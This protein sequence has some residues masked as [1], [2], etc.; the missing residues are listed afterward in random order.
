MEAFIAH[1]RIPKDAEP[2]L[3][4]KARSYRDFHN[5][6]LAYL[7]LP[8]RFNSEEYDDA[9]CMEYSGQAFDFISTMGIPIDLEMLRLSKEEESRFERA[10][11][12]LDLDV[13][14]HL[15][16]VPNLLTSPELTRKPLSRMRL[17]KSNFEKLSKA[18]KKD[19]K[20]KMRALSQGKPC[21]NRTS[22][23]FVNSR[24]RFAEGRMAEIADSLNDTSFRRR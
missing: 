4:Y 7:T 14:V 21:T 18:E 11:R 15:L 20:K 5:T 17:F 1:Q 8:S 13:T 24:P 16:Q 6:T 9:D 10:M 2:Y 23:V 19:E 12:I 22:F 3:D